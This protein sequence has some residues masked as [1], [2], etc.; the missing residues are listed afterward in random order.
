MTVILVGALFTAPFSVLCDASVVICQNGGY[1]DPKN[2]GICKC[3]LGFGGPLC[4]ILQPA[5]N[6]GCGGVLTATETV[7]TLSATVGTT[8]LT[9]PAQSCYWHI[10]VNTNLE[11]FQSP[12]PFDIPGISTPGGGYPHPLRAYLWSPVHVRKL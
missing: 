6:A 12:K 2:C 10:K 4:D 5:E 9:D 8:V 11:T 1:L 3:P 7:Q